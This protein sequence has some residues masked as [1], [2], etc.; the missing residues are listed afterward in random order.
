MKTKGESIEEKIGIGPWEHPTSAVIL[1][2]IGDSGRVKEGGTGNHVKKFL[3]LSEAQY[4]R[5]LLR[6]ITFSFSY[7]WTCLSRG[8]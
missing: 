5:A 8:V 2:K 1:S 4:K 7:P 6:C 3:L